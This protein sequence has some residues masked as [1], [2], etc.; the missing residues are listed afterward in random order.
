MGDSDDEYDRKRRD[1]FRGERDS[2]RG[3][4]RDDRSKRDDYER[5]RPRGPPD[6]REYRR[7]RNYSPER[8]PPVKRMRH[9]W[10]DV[11]PRYGKSFSSHSRQ[12]ITGERLAAPEPYGGGMYGGGGGGGY[13]GGHHEPYH[14]S[15]P[16]GHG[17]PPGVPRDSPSS[18]DGIPTQ[19]AMMTL[20]QFLATQDDSISDQ[21]AITKYNEY[22]V[23]FKRQQ[24]NEFFVAHKDEEW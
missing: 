17:P 1:K 4:R 8:G 3:D 23:E 13:G 22:K 9:D 20:K 18:N 11:R 2:Y 7:E 10:D 12:S 15:L 6:Y 24:L 16:F 5:S 19:P 14:S 21:D